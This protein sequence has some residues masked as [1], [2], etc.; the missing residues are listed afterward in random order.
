MW[1]A[2]NYAQFYANDEELEDKNLS[3]FLTCDYYPLA[4]RLMPKRN[5][6]TA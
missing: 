3:Y 1:I 5:A 4:L 2:E 6:I